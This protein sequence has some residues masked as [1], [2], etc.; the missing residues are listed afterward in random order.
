M[1]GDEIRLEVADHGAGM[2]E[3]LL[4]GSGAEFGV[5]IPGMRGRLRQL[6]GKLEIRSRARGTT[7]IASLP[8]PGANNGMGSPQGDA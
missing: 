5:G 7:V 3:R 8:L 2:P 4:N 1:R 6:G